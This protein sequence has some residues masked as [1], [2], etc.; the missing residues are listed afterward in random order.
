MRGIIAHR[1][2]Q[3]R[4]LIFTRLLH[5]ARNNGNILRSY[6]LKNMT[7]LFSKD[8]TCNDF[9]FRINEQVGRDKVDTKFF[10]YLSVS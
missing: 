2:K 9:P 1:A 3:Y 4:M 5:S 6:G 8:I 7:Q 10:G